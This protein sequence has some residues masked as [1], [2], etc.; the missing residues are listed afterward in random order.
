LLDLS[1]FLE[2]AHDKNKMSKKLL[3]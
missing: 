3:T 2:M 1:V